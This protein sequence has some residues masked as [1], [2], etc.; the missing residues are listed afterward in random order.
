[1]FSQKNNRPT[2]TL[3]I[4]TWNEY[5][6]I[7]AIFPLIPKNLFSRIL[8]VDGGSTDGTI[9]WCRENNIECFV[10]PRPGIR[11]AM[12]DAIDVLGINDDWILTFSP[13]GNSDPLFLPNM[14]NIINTSEFKIIYASRYK[15]K[16][17][18]EDDDLITKFGNWLFTYLINLIFKSNLSDGMVI[19]RAFKTELI[20]EL[21]LHEEN[22][23]RPFESIFS[24]RIGWE[25]LM[26]V[27]VA[28][29]NVPFIE[30]PAKEPPR[31][32][33]E[34]KLQIIR[35]GLCFFSQLFREIWYTP[36]SIKKRNS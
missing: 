30:I 27:R 25:P 8:V 14:L 2:T 5:E 21:G 32:A 33:G 16:L 10:Q 15:N 1:M 36:E 22:S 13:D 26:S 17:K 31:I 29:Y 28:K 4:M 35:W 11:Y 9:E 24:T 23:Y 19:Y 18:S 3:M 6:G 34:R 7:K 20:F 12:L